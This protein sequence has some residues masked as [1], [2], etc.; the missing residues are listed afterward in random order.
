[1]GD[2]RSKIG[3]DKVPR[4][5]GRFG[6][7]ERDYK[8][9]TTMK[10]LLLSIIIALLILTGCQPTTIRDD[11]AQSATLPS[12]TASDAVPSASPTILSASPT[13]SYQRTP[14]PTMS[15]ETQLKIVELLNTKD[16][17]FPCYFD[18][19]PGVTTW[20]AT[21]SLLGD[22]GAVVAAE[23]KSPS[24][25]MTWYG[26]KF[27]RD[28][29]NNESKQ[30]SD[31]LFELHFAMDSQG[32]VQQIFAWFLT[33]NPGN[34]S[35]DYWQKHSPRNVFMEIGMPDEIYSI[36]NAGGLALVYKNLGFVGV[37]D[38]L[39]DGKSLC[40]QNIDRLGS[41]SFMMTNTLFESVD[42][43]PLNGNVADFPSLWLSVEQTLHVSVQQFYETVLNDPSA[44]FE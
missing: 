25:N 20:A 5:A 18:V 17:I 6:L 22:T 36:K 4:R 42:I 10:R 29:V 15:L 3:G 40:P 23:S 33:H 7:P 9:V 43:Y 41:M 8:K 14:V 35:P 24:G 30:N 31:S 26:Y 16:C 2:L 38:S 32:I 27:F 44:C 13:G 34:M 28:Y 21:K 19:T 11:P 37:Y 39:W 1:M 12:T